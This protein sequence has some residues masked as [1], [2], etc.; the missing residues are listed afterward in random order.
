MATEN[1]APDNDTM[2]TLI[3]TNEQLSLA[4]TKHQRAVLQTRKALGVASP[5]PQLSPSIS[6]VMT[7]GLGP[8][9][10]ASMFKPVAPVSRKS[11]PTVAQPAA[12]PAA[13]Q[14]TASPV[15]PETENPFKD[16]VEPSDVAVGS[17]I[18]HNEPYHPGFG[19]NTDRKTSVGGGPALDTTSAVK[20]GRS[21]PRDADDSDDDPYGAP[22][23]NKAPVYRY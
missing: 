12:Q 9:P 23:Q 7:T 8:A 22:A 15:S 18:D 13:S 19:S 3:E 17:V 14:R 16:P 11:F 20:D 4:T 10:P 5:D 2:L 1:P 21:Q 6:P